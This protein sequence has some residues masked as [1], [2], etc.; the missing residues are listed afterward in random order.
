[1]AKVN[2]VENSFLVLEDKDYKEGRL[3]FTF[4]KHFI[5]YKH[6]GLLGQLTQA[7]HMRPPKMGE[8]KSHSFSFGLLL[9]S[10][11][12]LR[13]NS[14][15]RLTKKQF[16]IPLEE[17]LQKA[18]T[19]EIVING[20]ITTGIF[21]ID[22]SMFPMDLYDPNDMVRCKSSKQPRLDSVVRLH[23]EPQPSTSHANLQEK[24]PIKPVITTST[25]IN[26]PTSKEFQAVIL[27]LYKEIMYEEQRFELVTTGSYVLVDFLGG[28]GN[29]THYTY[30]CVVNSL[31]EA[32]NE[33]ILFY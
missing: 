1:M 3:G 31:L 10:F 4:L 28:E 23:D 29:K 22:S 9:A 7:H 27:N 6:D 26:V 2:K 25:S 24:S 13:H 33:Y 5:L 18:V 32:S 20:F 21:P 12:M 16:S 14:T 17:V 15:S 11:P 8:W 19:S 30:V